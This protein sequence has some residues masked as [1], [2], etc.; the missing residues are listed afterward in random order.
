MNE[1]LE[2]WLEGRPEIVK[3][4]ARKYPPGTRLM[5]HGKI[6][7]VVAYREDGGITVTDIDPAVDYENSLLHRHP[8]C[9]CCSDKLDE[10][11]L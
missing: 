2:L 9:P 8:L 11:K 6:H 5:L 1:A 3:Q 10:I 7:Y 4:L